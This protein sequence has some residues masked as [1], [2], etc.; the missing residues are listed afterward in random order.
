MISETQ[1]DLALKLLPPAILETLYMVF[2]SAFFGSLL[3]FPLG[4]LLFLYRPGS[5]RP[6]STLYKI[7]GLL[8]NCGRSIPFA[9]LMIAVIPFTRLIVGTSLGTTASIVP[10]SLA[11]APLIARLVETALASVDRGMHDAATVMGATTGQIVGK[12][13]IPECLPAFFAAL[14]LTLVSLVGY[15]AMAGLIGGG[16]LGQVAIQYGY[17]RFNGFIMLLTLVILLVM[18]EV[19]QWGGEKLVARANVKR[20]I[21]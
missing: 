3:G 20:G 13:Y 16:G 12:V 7:L 10:L 14:T 11:A 9:I 2:G 19:I 15:S 18:V 21:R 1:V 8:V 4:I 6:H 17:Q 5:L